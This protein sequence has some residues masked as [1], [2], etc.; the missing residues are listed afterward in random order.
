MKVRNSKGV[1]IWNNSLLSKNH[2]RREPPLRYTSSGQVIATSISRAKTTV[3]A[4]SKLESS[5]LETGKQWYI[6]SATIVTGQKLTKKLQSFS[7]NYFIVE[8]IARLFQYSLFKTI[9]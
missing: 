5:K 1:F 7:F 9:V 8:S 6:G 4:V 3:V 2:G